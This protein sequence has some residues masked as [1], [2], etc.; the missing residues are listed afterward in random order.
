MSQSIYFCNYHYIIS[1][2]LSSSINVYKTISSVS[3]ISDHVP[4]FLDVEWHSPKTTNTFDPITYQIST[5]LWARATQ[6]QAIEQHQ[7][8][9]DF[10]L[11][12]IVIS[13][14]T[15]L[16]AFLVLFLLI[17][18][19][20]ICFIIILLLYTYLPQTIYNLS[21]PPDKHKHYHIGHQNLILPENSHYS[22]TL[23]GMQ[24]RDHGRVTSLYDSPSA[25]HSCVTHHE[26][27]GLK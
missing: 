26:I 9:L 4:V 27:I 1:S 8:R 12:N 15:L 19:I 14:T 2:C 6:T 10:Y 22:G 16:W 23:Y 13:Y 17:Y 21:M 25:M 11:S 18:L 7:F 3:N 20:W 5:P 24:V